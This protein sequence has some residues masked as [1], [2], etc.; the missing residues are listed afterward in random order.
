M[1]EPVERLLVE[2]ELA[3]LQPQVRAS[4]ERL[5]ALL[6][7]DFRE[8]AASGRVFGKD[9]VLR[10]LPQETGVGFEATGFDVR[11]IAP[12]V[13]LVAYRAQRRSGGAHSR[14]VRSS[15]WR[16]E[17]GRWRMVFHQGTPLPGADN[18]GAPQDAP[19]PALPE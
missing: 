7:D 19:V 17:A 4:R 9:E 11:A 18:I 13:A 14:S 16:R 1:D 10:R 6:C 3:L 12:D 15:L 8:I 2:L 5:D